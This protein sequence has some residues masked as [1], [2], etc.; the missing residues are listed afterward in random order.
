MKTLYKVVL[1]FLLPFILFHFCPFENFAQTKSVNNISQS[2]TSLNTIIRLNNH[3]GIIADA[4]IRR[5]NFIADPNFYFLRTGVQ[6][7]VNDHFSL[8]AGIG[9]MWVAPSTPNWQHFAVENRIYQQ[10]LL[11][12]K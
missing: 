9:K 4:H 6:F 5:T 8:T 10:A 7:W 2:W 3:W 1:R 11:T 12:S